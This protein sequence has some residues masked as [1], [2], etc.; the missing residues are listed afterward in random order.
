MQCNTYYAEGYERLHP[1]I[2][3]PSAILAREVAPPP[4]HIAVLLVGAAEDGKDI[5]PGEVARV[6]NVFGRL[7]GTRCSVIRRRR[8]GRG[9]GGVP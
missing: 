6:R 8:R 4:L 9:W 3:Q 7:D 1:A 2:V 5:R